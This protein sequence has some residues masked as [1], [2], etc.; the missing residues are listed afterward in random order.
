MKLLRSRPTSSNKSEAGWA[1]ASLLIFA[2]L[3]CRKY[4]KIKYYLARIGKLLIVLRSALW[5]GASGIED[6][7]RNL[8][9]S[10]VFIFS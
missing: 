9:L 3:S 6:N 1:P 4:S 10:A 2:M 5:H 8:L 7:A